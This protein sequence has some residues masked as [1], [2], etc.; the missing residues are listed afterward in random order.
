MTD[1][2]T[3]APLTGQFWTEGE[4]ICD[5]K[6]P[7]VA[8]DKVWQITNRSGGGPGLITVSLDANGGVCSQSTAYIAGNGAVKD[9]PTPTRKGFKFLGWFD[10]REG[11][12][13]SY[14]SEVSTQPPSAALIRESSF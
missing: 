8:I 6:A 3:T 1:A 5:T 13:V 11:L 7:Q 4:D 9:L 14:I 12:R 10:A 2:I